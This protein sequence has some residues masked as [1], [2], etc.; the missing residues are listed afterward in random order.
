MA[1]EIRILD[2]DG[3]LE[4]RVLFLFPIATPI[5]VG[6]SNVVPT[7]TSGLDPLA[8]AILTT[9]EENALNAGTSAY[10]TVT[11]RKDPA[12]TNPQLATRMKEIYAAQKAVF[13]AAYTA[14]YQHVGTAINFP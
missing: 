8:L 5:L 6:G 4:Y 1:N 7:P 14:R 9:N 13:D 3:N 2:G 10:Q 12:L 11:F